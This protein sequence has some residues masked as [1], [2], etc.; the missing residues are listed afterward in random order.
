M[1]VYLIYFEKKQ[2][3]EDGSFSSFR[4]VNNYE[5]PESWI[6]EKVI[7]I[8]KGRE[9]DATIFFDGVSS[10]IFYTFDKS[11]LGVRGEDCRQKLYD[12]IAGRL[13]T[14]CIQTYLFID[15][16]DGSF[17]GKVLLPD[18]VETICLNELEMVFSQYRYNG[19]FKIVQKK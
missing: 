11:Y 19:F 4:E 6:S 14:G 3:P 1:S 12:F 2:F 16:F 17:S 13:E 18:K 9:I 8:H 5:L 15:V 10:N 7:V